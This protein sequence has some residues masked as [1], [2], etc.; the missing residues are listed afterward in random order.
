MKAL[1]IVDVQNDFCPGGT[2]AVAGG[3]RVAAPL[4]RLAA[5]MAA[6]GESDYLNRREMQRRGIDAAKARGKHMGRPKAAEASAVSAWRAEHGASIA[7]TAENFGLSVATVK[8]Y[9][10]QRT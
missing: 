8:R 10:A 6:Q 7:K 1:V 9:C 2:L 5:F 3:D 4:A